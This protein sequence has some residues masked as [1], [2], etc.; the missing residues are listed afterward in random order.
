MSGH[1]LPRTDK[2]AGDFATAAAVAAEEMILDVI[3]A[4]RP[5]DAVLS[6]EG[7]QQGAAH[8]VAFI[9]AKFAGSVVGFNSVNFTGRVVAFSGAEFTGGTVRFNG[10][11]FTRDAVE[12]CVA[13]PAWRPG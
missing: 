10:A 7:G 4:A 12:S 13:W 3:R 6:E 8:A 11:E 1:W 5:D 2:A 9:T